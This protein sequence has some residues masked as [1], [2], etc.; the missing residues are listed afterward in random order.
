MAWYDPIPF[1]HGC[2]VA[3]NGFCGN[4][5]RV[6]SITLLVDNMLLVF[7]FLEHLHGP[8]PLILI[9]SLSSMSDQDKFGDMAL[10]LSFLLLGV[11]WWYWLEHPWRSLVSSSCFA[12]YLLGLIKV[13]VE[14]GRIS[15]TVVRLPFYCK[16]GCMYYGW[17]LGAHTLYL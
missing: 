12:W 13:L 5:I 10:L 17:Y 3:F 1:R 14:L 9:S 2:L 7:L 6:W 4:F 15:F 8:T 16:T 11:P